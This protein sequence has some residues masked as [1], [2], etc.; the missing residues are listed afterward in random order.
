MEVNENRQDTNELSPVFLP[1]FG[2][3]ISWAMCRNPACENFGLPYE[4]PFLRDEKTVSDDRYRIDV[5]KGRIRCK[6]CGLSSL[7]KCNRAV[8]PLAR[9]FLRLSLPFED[10]P[11]PSCS[12]HGTNV[13]ENYF[14]PGDPAAQGR[15]RP[16]RKQDDH[17]V[18]CRNCGERF[19]LGNAFHLSRNRA[20]KRELVELMKGVRARRNF[21]DTVEET[22]TA[23]SSYYSRLWRMAVRLRDWQSWRNAQ[24]LHPKFAGGKEPIRLFTDTLRI[25]LKRDADSSRYTYLDFL[26]TVVALPRRSYFLL[27]IHPTFLPNEYC[28]DP[29][30]L[31]E[32]LT[33]P[34]YQDEWDC[35]QYGFGRGA[36]ATVEQ[37]MSS[38]PNLGHKGY[39]TT[40]FY[41]EM[42]HFLVLGKLLSRFPKIHLYMDGSRQLYSAALTAFAEDIRQDRV[43]IALFQ[44]IK[45]DSDKKKKGAASTGIRQKWS[46]RTQAGLNT[47]WMAQRARFASQLKNGDLQ[48]S[49]LERDSRAC[50][51]QFKFAFTGAHSKKGSWAWLRFPPSNSQF[52]D[53]RTLWLTWNPAKDFAKHGKELL[54]AASLQLV[55]SALDVLRGR[56]HGMRRAAYRAKAGPSYLESYAVPSVVLSELWIA[57]FWRNYR[58][59]YRS[60]RQ[61]SP[62]R[63]LNLIPPK[64]SEPDDIRLIWDFRLGL[65]LARRITRWVIQ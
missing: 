6:S 39:F 21:G 47:A 64:Q 46:R 37:T 28:P 36:D 29:M 9:Y 8:R 5:A 42:A 24:L 61:T 49:D 20:I 15:A 51:Q 57:L 60:P 22:H 25:S 54:F 16:Y 10:C 38:L 23:T 26:T 30:R 40:P 19:R 11:D 45:E 14:P 62:A 52:R 41:S 34:G 33:T 12:N 18:A 7:L 3:S 31:S 55:D 1:E 59:R 17:R 32:E 43:E 63:K 35:L 65:K 4:G 56:I 50:A 58:I 44:Y 13:F 2:R 27:A 48:L 53:P